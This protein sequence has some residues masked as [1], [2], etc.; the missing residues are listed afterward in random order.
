[1]AMDLD[2]ADEN[3]LVRTLMIELLSWQFASPV[4]WIETQELLIN[5]VDEIVEIGLAASPTLTNLALRSM[6]VLGVHVPVFNVERDQDVV[7][8]NDVAQ[9]PVF[10]EPEEEPA[11]EETAPAAPAAQWHPH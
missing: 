6:D 3:S 4:R 9:P 10:E 5:N 11:A 7:M 2:N 8:L 1:M